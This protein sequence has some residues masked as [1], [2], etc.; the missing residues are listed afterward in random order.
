MRVTMHLKRQLAVLCLV[1]E[2]PSHRFQQ[3]VEEHLLGLH[4]DRTRLD[5]RKIENVADQVQQIGSRAVNGAGEL[6]LLR[7]Q[8]AIRVVAELLSQHQNAVQRRAQLVRHV[9]QEL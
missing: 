1:P 7:R 3:V 4:R 5:L 2:W 8:V 9:G 6:D